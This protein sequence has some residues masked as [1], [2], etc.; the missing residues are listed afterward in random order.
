MSKHN[1]RR[2][3]RRNCPEPICHGYR[4]GYQDGHGAGYAAG[5][6]AGHNDGYVQAVTEVQ[7]AVAAQQ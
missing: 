2:C 5:Y 3:R 7:A 4:T 6:Q 1:P